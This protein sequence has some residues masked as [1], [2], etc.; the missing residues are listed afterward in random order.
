MV[1]LHPSDT[2]VTT[3]KNVLHL[4]AEG[5]HTNTHKVWKQ[6]GGHSVKDPGEFCPMRN[7]Q[8]C[9]MYPQ[10]TMQAVLECL[11]QKLPG[12]SSKATLYVTTPPKEGVEAVFFCLSVNLIDV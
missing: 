5:T 12:R 6:E 2:S 7:E 9:T 10:S 4:C 8:A 11:Q 1:C 3:S